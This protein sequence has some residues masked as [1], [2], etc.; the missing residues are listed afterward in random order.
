MHRWYSHDRHTDSDWRSNHWVIINSESCNDLPVLAAFLSWF[1]ARRCDLGSLAR[2]LHV[3]RILWLL[4]RV[5]HLRIHRV[6]RRILRL[7]E[8]LVLRAVIHLVRMHLIHVS[9]LT[10][11]SHLHVLLH[12][13]RARV[14]HRIIVGDVATR[15]VLVWVHR[16]VDMGA[17]CRSHGNGHML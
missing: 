7:L 10:I 11:G 2:L 14:L 1:F 8:V 15:S 6:L 12:G 9:L 17:R 5:M 4:G 16:Q 3:W 13:L